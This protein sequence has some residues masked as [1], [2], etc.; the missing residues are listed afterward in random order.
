[1]TRP[2]IHICPLQEA[3]VLAGRLPQP[4]HAIGLLG[5]DMEHPPLPLPEGRR[6]RLSFHDVAAETP[7][8]LPPKEEDVRRLVAFARRWRAQRGR[9]LLVHCWAGV[10]RST[11]AAYIVQCALN[12]EAD[13]FTLAHELRRLAPF[14]TPNARLVALADALLGREGR[15][16]AAIAE[17]G[18]GEEAFIGRPVAWPLVK[19]E[20]AA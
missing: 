20:K 4:V 14:A 16:T 7:G 19:A 8:F 3:P 13:E 12:P 10:S 6:L 15:M 5:P 1:M 18:R 11:A 2:A 9:A 17:I